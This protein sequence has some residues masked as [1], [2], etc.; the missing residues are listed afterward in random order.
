ML[1]L[2]HVLSRYASYEG[3]GHVVD[4]GGKFYWLYNASSGEYVTTSRSDLDLG[5]DLRKNNLGKNWES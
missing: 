1:L 4:I 5:P 3:W 2:E